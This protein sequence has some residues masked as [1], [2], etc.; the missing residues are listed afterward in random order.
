[1][2]S[3]NQTG[4]TLT[5]AATIHAYKS[6]GTAGNVAFDMAFNTR[7]NGGNNTEKMRITSGGNVG[8]GP[9]TRE[10]NCWFHHTSTATGLVIYNSDTGASTYSAELTISAATTNTQGIINFTKVWPSTFAGQILYDFNGDD[11]YLKTNGNNTRMFISCIGSVGIGTTD[12][13]TYRF[14]VYNDIGGDFVASFRNDGNNANRHGIEVKAG[15]D[16]ASGVTYYFAAQDGDGGGIGSLENNN[17]TF[18]LVDGSDARYKR[19][20]TDT[21]ITGIDT[22]NKVRVID[23]T[24]QKSD[25]RVIGGFS[26]QELLEVYPAAVSGTEDDVDEKGMPRP[27]GVAKDTFIPVLVK[28]I[29]ELS[30]KVAALEAA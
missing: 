11:M 7:V 17:G 4:T 15:A 29:Q 20:I 24:R 19:D 28:A 21:V 25:D 30:V 22:L 14:V 10:I 2:F 5:T 13:G 27:M 3:G 8:I 18:Q 1:M 12:P 26:A 6:N 23:F 9:E 16:D